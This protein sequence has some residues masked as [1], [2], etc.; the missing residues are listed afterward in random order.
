MSFSS[1]VGRCE[2]NSAI[3]GIKG[4]CV[5]LPVK[6]KFIDKVACLIIIPIILLRLVDLDHFL[7]LNNHRGYLDI[8]SVI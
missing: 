3:L 8:Q 2:Y 1:A 5:G 4:F 7:K 6:S